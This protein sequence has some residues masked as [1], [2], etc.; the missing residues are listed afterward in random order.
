MNIPTL[1]SPTAL[2]VG[3]ALV[4]LAFAGGTYVGKEYESG[5]NAKAKVETMADT[6]DKIG[7]LVES[8]KTLAMEQAAKEA[9]AKERARSAR[10]KGVNDAMV[11]ANAVC[12]RDAVSLGLLND[13]IDAANAGQSPAAGVRSQVLP[14]AEA[15]G[16]L[17]QSAQGL[18]VRRN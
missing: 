2:L 14:A 9:T 17:G 16:R 7:K 13:A 6:I 8:D 1:P 15:D 18:G 11:K 3:L 12:D 5:Q 4:V 10:A